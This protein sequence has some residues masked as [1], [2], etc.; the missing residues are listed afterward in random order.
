LKINDGFPKGYTQIELLNSAPVSAAAWYS[1][2]L[3][4]PV[5]DGFLQ[6]SPQGQFQ[7]SSMWAR[8]KAADGWSPLRVILTDQNR[9][10]GGFQILSRGSRATKIGYI[11]KGP[12]LDPESPELA[13]FCMRIFRELVRTEKVRAVILQP[14]DESKLTSG[15]LVGSPFLEN[16]LS[17]VVESTAIIDFRSGMLEVE[18]G[19]SPIA[20]KN[21]RQAVKRGVTVREAALEEAPRFFELMSATC[22][23]QKTRPNPATAGA[24]LNVLEA[25]S[26]PA[27]T[28]LTFAEVGGEVIAGLLCINFGGVTHL[29]KKGWLTTHGNRHPNELLMHEALGWSCSNGYKSCDFG[30]LD[31][32]IALSLLKGEGLNEG[33]MQSRHFFNLRFGA[34]P[35]LLPKSR[36]YIP[37]YT[38]RQLYRACTAIIRLRRASAN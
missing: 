17:K 24:L 13:H 32:R 10:V 34:R 29:W 6:A 11:S 23:R 7:Q 30:A 27:S 18:K 16:F 14:P 26:S 1:R 4:D 20:R 15:L 35:K 33:D 37:S 22:K 19:M 36:V 38:L 8:S 12:V 21:V 2:Q 3:E 31:R 28:R 9:L 25:F 5:W